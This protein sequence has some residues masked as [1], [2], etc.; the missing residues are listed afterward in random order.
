MEAP[1]HLA[2]LLFYCC[3]RYLVKGAGIFVSPLSQVHSKGFTVDLSSRKAYTESPL[4]K[5]WGER[6]ETEP[7]RIQ[8][9]CSVNTDTVLLYLAV[10]ANLN[11]WRGKR[12][13]KLGP[14][15]KGE[16]GREDTCVL[17]SCGHR[18]EGGGPD[19]PQ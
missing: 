5:Q 16:G 13:E 14:N 3:C 19:W 9:G 10:K 11:Q 6:G 15:H 4:G 17:R 12:K 8:I 7:G 2:F 18:R 1:D